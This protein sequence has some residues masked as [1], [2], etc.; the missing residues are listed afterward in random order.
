MSSARAHRA[1]RQRL[2]EEETM[3]KWKTKDVAVV[4]TDERRME[5]GKHRVSPFTT[6]ISGRNP[7][8]R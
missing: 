3:K 7:G 1:K 2:L 4:T 5:A 8:Y 6:E